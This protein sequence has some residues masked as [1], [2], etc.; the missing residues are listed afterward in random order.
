M[1]TTTKIEEHLANLTF[2]ETT[3]EKLQFLTHIQAEIE[4]IINHIAADSGLGISS[5]PGAP[6]ASPSLSFN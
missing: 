1:I 3:A 5:A 6:G 4:V 2:A